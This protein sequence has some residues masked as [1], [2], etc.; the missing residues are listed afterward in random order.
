[1]RYTS[2]VVFS[3]A[4][5]FGGLGGV[6]PRHHYRYLRHHY[7]YLRD[8]WAWSHGMANYYRYRCLPTINSFQSLVT[9]VN[10]AFSLFNAELYLLHRCGHCIQLMSLRERRKRVKMK[11]RSQVNRT[12][13]LCVHTIQYKSS[14]PYLNLGIEPYEIC[15]Q[16]YYQ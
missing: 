10:E 2:D 1:M 14:I 7:H 16:L 12:C 15:F 9:V 8:M 11:L 13:K 3:R 6:V 4:N 5:R